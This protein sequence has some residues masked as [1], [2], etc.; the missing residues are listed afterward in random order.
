MSKP[1][2]RS[3]CTARPWLYKPCVNCSNLFKTRD[4]NKKFCGNSCR[5]EH[6]HAARKKAGK[7]FDVKCWREEEDII[8][9]YLF[10]GCRD[11]K[12]IQNLLPGRTIRS[13]EHRADHLGA[14]TDPNIVSQRRREGHL[15]EKNGFFGRSHSKE[16]KDKLSKINK[17]HNVFGRL[18]KD[19]EFQRKRRKAWAKTMNK[20]GPSLAEQK[21]DSI[22]FNA[23]PG[24]YRF[25][26]DGEYIIDG[27]NPDWVHV[28][29]KKVIE[30]FGR[31]FHDPKHAL[32]ELS[33]RRTEEGRTE[34]FSK[35]GY[36]T[37]VIWDDHLNE[38]WKNHNLLHNLTK[39]IQDFTRK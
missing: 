30:L 2:R 21:L 7:F 6:L 19:P 16:T 39:Q 37:L 5:L 27:L 10:P 28:S 4:T 12:D 38:V 14:K 25:V 17:E 18:N 15:G 26:G 33:P 36:Q 22:I 35:H 24:Q 8:V 29:K 9:E 34:V 20:E 31:A 11:L 13:I 23:C 1:K 32:W 3:P